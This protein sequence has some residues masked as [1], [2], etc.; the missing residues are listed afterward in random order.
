[1]KIILAGDHA[2]YELK[3]IIAAKLQEMGHTVKDAGPFSNDSVDL[4][5]FV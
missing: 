1:M 3:K 4:S 5:D 2:G